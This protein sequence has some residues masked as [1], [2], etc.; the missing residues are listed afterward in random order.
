MAATRNGITGAR[1][2]FPAE[3]ASK[4]GK[5]F[6]PIPSQHMAALAVAIWGQRK[7]HYSVMT[8]TAQVSVT[9]VD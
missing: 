1:A 5:D 9:V 8:L 3:T 4:R 6:V 7:R 2:Q